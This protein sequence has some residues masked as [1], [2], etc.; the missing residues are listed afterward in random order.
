[1]RGVAAARASVGSPVS[2]PPCRARV[3][4]RV[5]EPRAAAP[6]V[7]GVGPVAA[8]PPPWLALVAWCRVA[9]RP[10]PAAVSVCAAGRCFLFVQRGVG[11]LGWSVTPLLTVC[12]RCP[13]CSMVLHQY[14]IVGRKAPTESDP[15]PQIYRMRLFAPNEVL[16]KSRFWY[17]LHQYKKMKRATGQIISVN[18]VWRCPCAR[19]GRPCAQSIGC[20]G[21]AGPPRSV[22]ATTAP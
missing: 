8:P 15:N 20:G 19:A 5:D 6:A 10:A 21:V 4:W 7:V 11:L 17:F 3:W 2:L 12:V 1:M 22:S 16:A 18:E 9:V 14:Q 13:P